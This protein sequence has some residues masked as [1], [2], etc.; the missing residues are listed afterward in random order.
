MEEIGDVSRMVGR[1]ARAHSGTAAAMLHTLGLYP[2]QE[3]LLMRLWDTGRQTQGELT[4]ALGLDP[5][6]V[7]RTVQCLERQ[8]LIT[9][10]SS[11]TDRRAVIV[12]L[13]AAGMELRELVEDFWHKLERKA[14]RDLSDR[15]RVSALR[16]LRRIEANLAPAA[17]REAAERRRPPAAGGG[18]VSPR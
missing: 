11:P 6:T 1:V 14:T 8:G 3:A 13:T 4:S 2:G 12:E 7:T 5:S 16:L 18:P 15:Q 9:R 17:P 10:S